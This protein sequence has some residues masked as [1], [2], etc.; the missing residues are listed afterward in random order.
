MMEWFCEKCNT[1]FHAE[2]GSCYRGCNGKCVPFNIQYH[3]RNLIGLSNG[4]VT[5]WEKWKEHPMVE[6]VA[7]EHARNG[8]SSAAEILNEAFERIEQ[9]ELVDEQNV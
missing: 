7:K 8:N 5:V 9:G 4:W 2:H 6:H 1:V 3:G